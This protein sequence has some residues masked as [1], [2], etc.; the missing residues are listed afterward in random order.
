MSQLASE[1]A[2]KTMTKPQLRKALQRRLYISNVQNVDAK[3]LQVE[4]EGDSVLLSLKYELR[5]HAVGNVDAVV[6]FSESITV[7]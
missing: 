4:K 6:K 2:L 5:V 1:P 3:K 7:H